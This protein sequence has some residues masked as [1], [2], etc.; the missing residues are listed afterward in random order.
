MK[1]RNAF[2]TLTICALLAFTIAA[3]V[4]LQKASAN[5]MMDCRQLVTG[6]YLTTNSGSV[7]SFRTILTFAKDGNFFSI[8]SNESGT[9]S[10]VPYSDPQGSWKCT[11]DREITAIALDFIDPTATSSGQI[12]RTDYVA[13]FEPNKGIVQATG[14]IRSFD[15]NANPLND[16]G[17]GLG[18]FTFTGERVKP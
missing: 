16:G 2:A 1:T 6:T 11:S 8:V 4:N 9:P 5:Y 14:T 15:L 3:F 12:G 18:N 17:L 13:R 10:I 7:G